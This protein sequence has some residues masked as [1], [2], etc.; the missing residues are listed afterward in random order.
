MIGSYWSRGGREKRREGGNV[1][2]RINCSKGEGLSAGKKSDTLHRKVKSSNSKKA[3]ERGEVSLNDF[4]RRRLG[5]SRTVRISLTLAASEGNLHFLE[6]MEKRSHFAKKRGIH[7]KKGKVR[8][9]LSLHPV[10]EGGILPKEKKA[11]LPN[12][13]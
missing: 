11:K 2:Q 12:L 3:G 7:W 6:E 10:L 1:R 9:P 5:T 4:L 13:G 8:T